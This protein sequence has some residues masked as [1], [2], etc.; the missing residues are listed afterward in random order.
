MP[1]TPVAGMD[2][3]V[4]RL[5]NELGLQGQITVEAFRK[6][7]EVVG[8]DV[9]EERREKV[10]HPCHKCWCGKE[11]HPREDKE[12]QA[13]VLDVGGWRQVWHVPMRCRSQICP[14]REN[15]V[16]YNYITISKTE[17][18]WAW[19]DTFELKYF[20]VHNQW[21]V[22]TAWLRQYQHRMAFQ[23]T[24]FESEAVVHRSCAARDG[25]ARIVPS[26]EENKMMRAWICWRVAQFLVFL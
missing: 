14:R 1:K 20:F 26:K 11:L 8:C 3:H 12:A 10:R 18:L 24:A 21:G 23:Y 13:A 17:H 4:A 5:L 16:W 7:A 22:T 6:A 9:V 15:Y 25:Q 2:F 19:E